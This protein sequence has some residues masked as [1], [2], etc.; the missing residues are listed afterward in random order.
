MAIALDEQPLMQ[1]PTLM[2]SVLVGR[3]EGAFV[4]APRASVS[5][6]W[7]DYVHCG[8]LSRFEVMKLL[9]RLALFGPPLA[10]PKVTQGRCRTVKLTSAAPLA[11]HVDGEFFCVPEENIRSVEIDIRPAA[12]TIAPYESH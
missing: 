6:G 1:V 2:L 3:R 10:Y 5:D 8:D 11:I 12:L 7:F 4:M 9:P